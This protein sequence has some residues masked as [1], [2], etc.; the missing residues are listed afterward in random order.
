MS[1]VKEKGLVI[2]HSVIKGIIVKFRKSKL[3]NIGF[4]YSD[5]REIIVGAIH[6]LYYLD[7]NDDHL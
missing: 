5:F 1:R 2:A 6:Y 3:G 4:Q 7:E